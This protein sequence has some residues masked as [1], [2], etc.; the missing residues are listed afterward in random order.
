MTKLVTECQV[1]LLDSTQTGD[2]LVYNAARQS[3]DRSADLY[4]KDRNRKLGITLASHNHV[5]PFAHASVSL[6]VSAPIFVAR[7]LDKTRVGMVWSEESRRYIEKDPEIFVFDKLRMGSKSIKQGSLQDTFVDVD[8][9]SMMEPHLKESLRLYH[10]LLDAGVCREQARAH[11]PQN[12][13]INFVWTGSLLGWCRLFTL[14]LKPDAQKETRD[15]VG[16]IKEVV[17]SVFPES[18]EIHEKVDR[19]KAHLLKGFPS[20]SEFDKYLE[21]NPDA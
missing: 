14:R 8:Y 1:S 21:D 3:M 18:V 4:D 15:C 9:I 5:I 20:S 7:Q 11:L 6:R 12:M 10:E 2:D 17:Q 13:M 16:K 19:I